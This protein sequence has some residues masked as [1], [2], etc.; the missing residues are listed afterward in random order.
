[1]SAQTLIISIISTVDGRVKSNLI[2]MEISLIANYTKLKWTNPGAEARNRRATNGFGLPS[3][4]LRLA[5]G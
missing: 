2:S 1:M 5:F 3:V 4:R